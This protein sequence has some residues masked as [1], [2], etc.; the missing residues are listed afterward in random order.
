MP[1]NLFCSGKMYHRWSVVVYWCILQR[2]MKEKKQMGIVNGYFGRKNRCLLKDFFKWG[3]GKK[4]KVSY[5]VRLE[6]TK[7]CHVLESVYY[8]AFQSQFE[9]NYS[10]LNSESA[11]VQMGENLHI[12]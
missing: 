6:P 5:L 11:P 2:Y 3:K 4:Q 7:I 1:L 9:K 10:L 8:V 12:H